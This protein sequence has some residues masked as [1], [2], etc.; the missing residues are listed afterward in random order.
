MTI[1]RLVG[2]TRLTPY[3]R[4]GGGLFRRNKKEAAKLIANLLEIVTLD[5]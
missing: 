3:Q 2:M 4:L 1:Y 5:F